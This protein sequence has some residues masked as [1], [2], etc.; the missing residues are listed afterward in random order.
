MTKAE[1]IEKG[2][3]LAKQY[4]VLSDKLWEK[5]QTGEV[6]GC[7]AELMVGSSPGYNLFANYINRPKTMKK[8][9]LQERINEMEENMNR[10][11]Q[12]LGQS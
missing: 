3:Q 2:R 9:E 11:K 1:L 5:I 6:H 8:F 7:N 12:L 10:I 4:K